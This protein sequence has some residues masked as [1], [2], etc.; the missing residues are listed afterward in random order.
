MAVFPLFINLE[1]KKCIVV[2]GGKVAAR[3]I[4]TLLK[5]G[6]SITVISPLPVKSILGL[7]CEDRLI[8]KRKKYSEE[9]IDG[10]FIIIAATS[11]KK[12]NKR[13]Y[14]DA[15]KNNIPVNVVDCPR[16]CTFIFPSIVKRND[17]VVGISTSGRYPALSKKM[18]EKIEKMLPGDFGDILEMLK[19]YRKKAMIEIHDSEKRKE[20]LNKIAD[21]AFCCDHVPV[22]RLKTGIEHIFKEYGE[23]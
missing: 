10:A 12:A 2:G 3:K 15:V 16:K 1:G 17:L 13:I 21:E 14:D 8:V 11:D 23:V 5:F 7:K 19:K 9:D 18:R 6:A 20:L 22:E 4:E